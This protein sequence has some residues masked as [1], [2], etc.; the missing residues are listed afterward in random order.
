[1]SVLVCWFETVTELR[2]EW[3]ATWPWL[4]NRRPDWLLVVALWPWSVLDPG[5]DTWVTFGCRRPPAILSPFPGRPPE[6]EDPPPPALPVSHGSPAPPCGGG[7]A[8]LL[9]WRRRQGRSGRAQLSCQ[10]WRESTS[11]QLSWGRNWNKDIKKDT[12]TRGFVRIGDKSSCWELTC[13]PGMMMSIY[14]T[15][16]SDQTG[17]KLFCVTS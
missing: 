5:A 7:G 3:M 13:R 6:D 15:L 4:S 8:A 11:Y 9:W 2:P 1:M 12:V 14:Q 10:S 17:K 16:M